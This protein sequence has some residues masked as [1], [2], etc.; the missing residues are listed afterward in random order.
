MKASEIYRKAAE[1]YSVGSRICRDSQECHGS[2]CSLFVVGA[3]FSQVDEY[4]SIFCPTDSLL[5]APTYWFDNDNER[6]LALLLMSE[7][8]KDEQK[9]PQ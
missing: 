4:R 6:V 7:I 2:C 3:Y 8:A 1:L 5:D 9:E